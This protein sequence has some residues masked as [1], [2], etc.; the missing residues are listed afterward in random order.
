GSVRGCHECRAR[1]RRRRDPGLVGTSW[2]ER[3]RND[4]I[5]L[6]HFMLIFL[7]VNLFVLGTLV[8]SLLNVCIHRLPLEKSIIWP[9]S[10]C[11]HC[12]QPIRWYDNIPLVSYLL[13]R[14]RCRVCGTKFSARYFLIE[15]LTGLSF[16]G[17]FYLEVV[18]DVHGL[19]RDGIQVGRLQLLWFPTWQAWVVFGF[20]A[21]LVCF[22][23][24]ASFC[25][26]DYREI[27]FSITIPGTVVGLIGAVLFPWPWPY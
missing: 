8:G 16:V 2:G 9:G 14:G 19:D 7:L 3:V 11:S 18:R 24:V 21:V 27:P 23:I 5:M 13:L 4:M 22:L 26:L 15:L 17:L 1:D 20:H 10:R 12:L 6:P 25:D